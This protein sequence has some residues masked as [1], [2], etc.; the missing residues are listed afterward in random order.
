MEG[1]KVRGIKLI[2][3][4]NFNLNYFNAQL[5]FKGQARV[6]IPTITSCYECS[7]DMLGKQRTFPI[8]TIANTPRLPEHCIE[9]ASVIQWPKDRTGYILI[10][11]FVFNNDDLMGFI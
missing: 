11:A 10:R 1:P 3:H 6:I 7:L 8:C 5:G 2:S 4:D 9:W